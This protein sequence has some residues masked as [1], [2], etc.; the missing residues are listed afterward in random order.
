MHL[1]I[2]A[3]SLQ[4]AGILLLLAGCQTSQDTS[5]Q[6]A[7]TAALQERVRGTCIISQTQIQNASV[8]AVRGGCACYAQRTIKAMTVA[9]LDYL[10]VKGVFDDRARD[11]GLLAIEACRLKRP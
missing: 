8:T 1:K 5:L 10:R 11:K 7:S 2:V 3:R 4:M 6:E 9:E